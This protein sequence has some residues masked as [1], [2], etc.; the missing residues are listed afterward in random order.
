MD[1]VWRAIRITQNTWFTRVR[2]GVKTS[3][4]IK[5]KELRNWSTNIIIKPAR[6]EADWGS[7]GAT[8]VEHV[9]RESKPIGTKLISAYPGHRLYT[10]SVGEATMNSNRHIWPG[11]V[12]G[13]TSPSKFFCSAS[14]KRHNTCQRRHGTFWFVRVVSTRFPNIPVTD[15]LSQQST[16][17]EMSHHKNLHDKTNQKRQR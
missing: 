16:A 11:K 1:Q 14:S 17:C 6:G 3:P 4:V 7:R 5:H 2:H 13:T 15:T 9:V 8:Y 12:S 10:D